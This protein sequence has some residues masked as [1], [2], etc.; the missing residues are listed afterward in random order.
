MGG[1]ALIERDWL[2]WAVKYARPAQETHEGPRLGLLSPPSPLAPAAPRPGPAPG[3]VGWGAA[4]GK[5]A[6]S[7]P[8]PPPS[9]SY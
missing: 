9:P 4:W 2:I 3:D 1:I 7:A 6:G 8:S 5:A